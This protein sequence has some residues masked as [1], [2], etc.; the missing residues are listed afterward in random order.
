MDLE[1]KAISRL[2]MAS[3]M[4][5]KLYGRPLIVTDS[6]GKDSA[7]IRTLAAR[8]GIPYEL[9]HNHTTVDAPETV[10]YVRN[11]FRE[12]ENNGIKCSIAYPHY[13]GKRVTMWDL[14]VE[15]MIPPTRVMRY[16]CDVCK[17][18]TGKDRFVVTGVRWA[19]SQSRKNKRAMLEVL[20]RDI[21]KILKLN[22]DND[23][24][25]QLFESCTLKGKRICTPI[26]DWKDDDV[27]DYIHAEKIPLN[28]LYMEGFCRVGC[29][30]CPM[31]GRAHREM[32]FSRWP[33]YRSAY[34]RAFDRM[35]EE[36]HRKGKDQGV[37][38]WGDT[39]KDVFHWWMED[40]VL[41]GQME[42]AELMKVTSDER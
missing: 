42:I 40:G 2:R 4:S 22:E 7:I 28:P 11:T 39:G 25:R 24:S 12:A 27:W 17:E 23:E 5:L 37:S 34:I 31:A 9:L 29:V 10:R 30:G 35:L 18:S 20:P 38:R 13:K 21:S 41:P 26:V 32:G 14:I 15:K 19:E 8:S 36:R 1:Q 6:G 16:C 3:D 33:T